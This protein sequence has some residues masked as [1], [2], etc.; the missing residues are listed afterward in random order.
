MNPFNQSRYRNEHALGDAYKI[1][2][3]VHDKMDIVK[4]V[5]DNISKF[6][7]GNIELKGE[8]TS[9]LWKYTEGT[10]WFLLV[11]TA[12]VFTSLN[13]Q[14]AVITS[15]LDALESAQNDHNK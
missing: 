6:R 3:E 4:M 15:R 8:G 12:D 5:A 13:T 14:L 9:I 7:S 10:A 11:D 1:V 2:K